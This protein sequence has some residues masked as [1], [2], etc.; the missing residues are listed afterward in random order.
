[1]VTHFDDKNMEICKSYLNWHRKFKK[2]ENLE[3]IKKMLIVDD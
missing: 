1:M 2:G 3:F